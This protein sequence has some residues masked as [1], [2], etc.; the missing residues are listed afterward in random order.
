MSLQET[1]KE[2]NRLTKTERENKLEDRIEQLE[3]KLQIMMK[4]IENMASRLE[5]LEARQ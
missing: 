5:Y 3:D 1:A 4:V 2:L